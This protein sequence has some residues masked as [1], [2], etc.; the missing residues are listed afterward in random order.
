M[1]YIK[2][3]YRNQTLQMNI[4]KT[5][6]H[7]SVLFLLFLPLFSNAIQ[8][9][10]H[11]GTFGKGWKVYEMQQGGNTTSCYMIA[12]PIQTKIS[13]P[14]KKRGQSYFL[15]A[16]HKEPY[17]KHIISF[18]AGY[19]L[20]KESRPH[21]KLDH[22]RYELT[23]AGKG[24]PQ[25]TAW[26]GDMALEEAI[27]QAGKGA[28]TWEIIGESDQGTQTTD[29]YDLTGFTTAYNTMMQTCHGQTKYDGK[30][31]KVEALAHPG[32]NTKKPAR[33]KPAPKQKSAAACVQKKTG[34][35]S[36]GRKS[37][38]KDKKR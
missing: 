20:K 28:K 25:D 30:Q 9:K 2:L 33:T 21:I 22:K 35:G 11:I 17:E 38:K 26:V 12:S 13:S 18:A 19:P 6:S 24:T 23:V 1:L 7:L 8:Q 31:R 34:S 3:R 10:K 27:V 36:A 5:V 32:K 14:G 15:I 16:T 37:Q 4:K 29:L